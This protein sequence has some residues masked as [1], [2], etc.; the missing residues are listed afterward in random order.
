MN[1][2]DVILLN[3]N[4]GNINALEALILQVSYTKNI[5][6]IGVGYWIPYPFL[7]E[8]VTKLFENV[9]EALQFIRG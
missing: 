9:D 4:N 6:I 2:Y 8:R 3:F 1:S 5:P 7:T